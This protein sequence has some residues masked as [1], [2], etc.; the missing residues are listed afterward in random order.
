MCSMLVLGMCPIVT[1][2]IPKFPATVKS[3]VIRSK[4]LTLPATLG[5]TKTTLSVKVF[6]DSFPKIKYV[7]DYS[8]SF[9][10]TQIHP[11]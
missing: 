6:M 4:P 8:I 9:G 3:S 7:V 11:C 10:I 2:A 1:V 5:I